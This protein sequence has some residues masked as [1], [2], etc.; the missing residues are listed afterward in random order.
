MLFEPNLR[1]VSDDGVRL[2]MTKLFEGNKIEAMDG[3][4]ICDEDLL[5]DDI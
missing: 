2:V 1:S 4:L 3:E 5:V